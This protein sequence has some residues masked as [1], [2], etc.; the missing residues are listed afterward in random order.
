[1]QKILVPL[2]AL[3]V[4]LSACTTSVISEEDRNLPEE[5]A[6]NAN[7]SLDAGMQASSAYMIDQTVEAD[8]SQS[9]IAFK[10]T[11][12]V[13]PSSHECA[14]ESYDFIMKKEGGTPSS[15]EVSI[16]V[17]SLLTESD[18]LTRHL[19]GA[20][21][22]DAE[23][24]SE[25]TF[26]STSIESKGGDIYEVTGDMTIHGT[27]NEETFDATITDTYLTINHTLDRMDYGVGAAPGQ[28]KAVDVEIPMEVKIVFQ[29]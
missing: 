17:D 1:M 19:L 25:A 8:M 24:Y 15:I 4:L 23:T 2:F 14:F 28:P 21:F 13:P 22:F 11:R 26:V 18:G 16:A 3:A 7:A 12:S 6:M 29:K 10:G 5:P 20:D 9:F 27:T